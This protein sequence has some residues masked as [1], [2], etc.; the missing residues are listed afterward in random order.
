MVLWSTDK[1]GFAR[2][3]CAFSPTSGVLSAP[4]WLLDAELNKTDE[5]RDTFDSYLQVETF[6]KV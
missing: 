1:K 4:C 5:E 6:K 3:M 2:I